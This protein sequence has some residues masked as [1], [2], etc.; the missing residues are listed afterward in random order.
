MEEAG[1][2]VILKATLLQLWWLY[3]HMHNCLGCEMLW[4]ATNVRLQAQKPL[5]VGLESLKLLLHTST[6]TPV[7]F[8]PNFQVLKSLGTIITGNFSIALSF[9]YAL[10]QVLF[11]GGSALFNLVSWSG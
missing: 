5:G 2:T 3:N 8:S 4:V 11:S 10:L 1:L 7:Y 6:L 9:L